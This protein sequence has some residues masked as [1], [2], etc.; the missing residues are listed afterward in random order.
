MADLS[1][2]QEA[3]REQL[4]CLKTSRMPLDIELNRQTSTTDLQ[5]GVTRQVIAAFMGHFQNYSS[6]QVPLG[7]FPATQ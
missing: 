5:A 1:S 6:T 4:G 7:S 2:A 3:D